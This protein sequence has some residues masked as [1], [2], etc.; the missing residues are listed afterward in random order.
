MD[1][2]RPEPAGFGVPACSDALVSPD[3]AG[4]RRPEELFPEA[5]LLSSIKGR[6]VAALRS[7]FS[8]G[9]HLTMFFSSRLSLENR[10]RK[11]GAGEPCGGDPVR[12]RSKQEVEGSALSPSVYRA[13]EIAR[14]GD[15][16]AGQTGAFMP[17]GRLFSVKPVRRHGAFPASHCIWVP[18]TLCRCSGATPAGQACVCQAQERFSILATA[19]LTLRAVTPVGCRRIA[20]S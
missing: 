13:S 11:P 12:H 2:K 16:A 9:G 8:P 20:S 17:R 7:Q 6:S 19:F 10:E 4:L 1:L 18:P 3:C 5:K 15:A 14:P